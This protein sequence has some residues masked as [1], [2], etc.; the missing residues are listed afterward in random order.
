MCLQAQV[1][2]DNDGGI[3]GRRRALGLNENDGGVGRGQGIDDTSEVSE[4]TK[5]ATR[6]W[7]RRQR[8][9][10]RD[11]ESEELVTTKEL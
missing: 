7:G 9:R 4:T 11:Y 3:S 5:E 6:I 10:R 1:I 8:L 2:D